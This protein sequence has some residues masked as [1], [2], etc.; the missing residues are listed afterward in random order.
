MIEKQ[1]IIIGA[2]T[3]GLYLSRLLEKQKINYLLL[4][5]KK[6]LKTH[7]PRILSLETIK[8]IGI[9]IKKLI[10]PI[11]EINF[12][13]PHE[14]KLSK[15]GNTIRGYIGD[16]GE[17]KPYLFNSQDKSKILFNHT[18]TDFDLEKGII[19]TSN[20]K[21][22]GFQILVFAN[23]ILEKKFAEKLGI[24]APKSIFCYTTETVGND[25]LTTIL[26]NSLAPGFFGWVV[27]LNHNLIELGFGSEKNNYKNK[28]EIQKQLFSIPHLREYSKNKINTSAGGFI[29]MS[30]V[31]KKAGKNWLIIG[32]AAGGEPLLGSSVHKGIDE[33][34]IASETITNYL[35][36]KSPLEEY[37]KSWGKFFGADIGKQK[38]FRKLLDE[39][40]ND[41]ID[42]V[43][44]QL[45][46]KQINGQGL[47]ND[48]FKNIL[49][50][51]KNNGK[52]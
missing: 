4:E 19:K 13:S 18:V 16:L 46:G 31:E 10:Q 39:T 8:A 44:E 49:V 43:F 41:A 21:T 20:N 1:V 38:E 33:A 25:K 36:K 47:I 28:K 17:I 22:F 48:L 45:R 32:D 35:N 9:P 27:P 23:G 12:Y 29:P 11:K 50:N 34:K 6:D 24:E 7:G 51:I 26:D 40:H 52:Q 42:T 30:I 3:A 15:K 5:K 14:L 37:T 2:G